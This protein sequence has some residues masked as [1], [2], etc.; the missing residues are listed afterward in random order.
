MLLSSWLRKH[1]YWVSSTDK[2]DRVLT[3]VFLDGGKA[4]VPSC[5]RQDFLDVY[6]QTVDA[7]QRIYAVERAHGTYRMFADLDVKCVDKCAADADAIM[8]ALTDIALRSLPGPLRVGTVVV[9]RR[10]YADGKI[11]AHWVWPGAYVDDK[12]AMRL[13]DAWV[14]ACV[15]CDAAFD[16]DKIVDAAVYKRNG[17]RMPW[18]CKR[19]GS[20]EAA[21]VPWA[22][23]RFDAAEHAVEPLDPTDVRALLD[24]STIDADSGQARSACQL[25]M[26]AEPSKTMMTR[27]S[28]GDVSQ[29]NKTGAAASFLSPALDSKLRS[30][31]HDISAQLSAAKF[32]RLAFFRAAAVLTTDC[33]HCLHAGRDHRSNKVYLVAVLHGGLYQCC[34]SP[35]CAPCGKKTRSKLSSTHPLDALIE[36]NSGDDGGDE[37]LDVP[38]AKDKPAVKLTP[39]TH[40][41]ALTAWSR[42][43]TSQ[44]QARSS[45]HITGQE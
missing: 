26:V 32:T 27:T 8:T 19:G 23:V 22:K 40:A 39:T 4:S 38:V 5:A 36:M 44:L 3:H 45:K 43:V 25:T 15:L 9:C 34:F 42:K 7:G 41:S 30:I 17:L 12:M 2:T 24:I 16:W 1:G 29:A 6:A 11:G 28:D 21:Y 18:S 33:R 10:A 13:R 35:S 37:Q 14:T 31:I 20:P